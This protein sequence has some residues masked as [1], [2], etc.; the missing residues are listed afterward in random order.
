[1]LA[2]RCFPVV[3]LA[4][5]A[6][7]SLVANAQGDDT[8][9]IGGKTKKTRGTILEATS[10]DIACY[11]KLRDDRGAV[12][13]EMANFSICEQQQSLVGKRVTLTYTVAN[14]MARECQGDIDCK[15]SDRIVLVA[16]ARVLVASTAPPTAPPAAPQPPRP[17]AGPA[18]GGQASFCTAL[19]TVV[20]SCRTGT[21][22]VSVCASPEAGPAWGYVQYRIGKPDSTE[23]LELTLPSARV[24]PPRAATADTVGFSG[25]GGAW[26]RFRS[27]QVAYVVHTGI[28]KWGP[29]G[30][31]Q[32]KAGV[33]VERAGKPIAT[34]KCNAKPQ[35]QL[36]PDWFKKAGL[37]SNNEDFDF[38][39]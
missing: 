8:V 18:A 9:V 16:T 3:L 35:S 32:E 31:I 5:L 15:K 21:K 37:K 39:D 27:G 20:F 7:G 23:P 25:G 24:P 19:E 6:F 17:A 38:S 36:G 30:E 33:V 11:L 28:G 2:S 13:D 12:F 14:V 10:G 29:R 1:M 34:L 26:M 4:A 22:L